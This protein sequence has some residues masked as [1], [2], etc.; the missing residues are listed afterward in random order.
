MN[1]SGEII[2]LSQADTSGEL[3]DLSQTEVY[4]NRNRV[5]RNHVKRKVLNGRLLK[6]K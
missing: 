6:R 3:I 4:T 5:S 1:T 2:D